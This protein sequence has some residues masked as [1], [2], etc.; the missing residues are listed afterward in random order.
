ML[1]QLT[2]II[3]IFAAAVFSAMA[4]TKDYVSIPMKAGSVWI[5]KQQMEKMEISDS[6]IPDSSLKGLSMKWQIDHPKWV[7][8][9]FKRGPVPFTLTKPQNFK[10]SL[11]MPENIPGLAFSLRFRDAKGEVFQVSAP[12]LLKSKAGMRE[13]NFNLDPQKK[14]L[15]WGKNKDGK[16]DWPLNLYGISMAFLPGTKA[17]SIILHSIEYGSAGKKLEQVDFSIDTN[18]PLNISTGDKQSEIRAILRSR[19]LSKFAFNAMIVV[20]DYSGRQLWAK[21]FDNVVLS[22]GKGF[23]QLIPAIDGRGIRSVKCILSNPENAQETLIK[24]ASYGVMVPAG[25][26]RISNPEFLFGVQDHSPSNP[27]RLYLHTLS[28]GLAGVKVIRGAGSC[29]S[30]VQPA[31]NKWDF[32]TLDRVVDAYARQNIEIQFELAFTPPWAIAE[33]Q[34]PVYPVKK[35]IFF[36]LI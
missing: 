11:Y 23:S 3:V 33:H 6:T 31:R 2:W 22:P 32:T 7:E 8:L 15:S 18:H 24:K 19:I 4:E 17:G 29:W 28:A 14:Y 25:P 30:A 27:D 34:T 5:P 1:K 12:A 10:L 20:E 16:I 9:F 35:K 21:S 26:N 36:F 13:V